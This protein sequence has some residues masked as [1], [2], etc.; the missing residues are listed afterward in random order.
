MNI[1]FVCTGN[2]CRSPMAEA[3]L[4]SKYKKG[5]VRSAGIFAGK[6]ESIAENSDLVLKEIDLTLN[7]QTSPVD[8]EM[9]AWADLILTMT[10][11]HKQTLAIQYPDYQE[12]Y[13]TLKEFVLIDEGEWQK[14][15]EFYSKFEEKRT[16]L[17][18]EYQNV[19]SDQELES[20]LRQ[21]LSE[22]I[23]EIERLEQTM[24]DVNVSD[25]FGGSLTVYRKTREELEKYIDMLVM[26]IE[27]EDE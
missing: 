27:A 25:P 8:E 13:Y 11:R 19:L 16:A 3:I 26:K 1:L 15:K 5:K 10:D 24:P 17:V 7:H 22:E 14:L 20:K 6:G 2:T 12:K 21:E 18:R 4:K 23:R 9:L